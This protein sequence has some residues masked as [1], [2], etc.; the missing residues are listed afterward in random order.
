MPEQEFCGPP[1]KNSFRRVNQ[2]VFAPITSY[3]QNCGAPEKRLSNFSR[4][5][6]I[7]S[8]RAK[9]TLLRRPKSA[10]VSQARNSG[11]PLSMLKVKDT[12]RATVHLSYDGRVFK[13][14]HG[15]NA[16]TAI[17]QRDARAA[18]PRSARL[19]FRSAPAGGGRKESPH[20][21]HQL[22]R[23]RR[24]HWTTNAPRNCS[25]NWKNSA[26][27]TTT[28]TRATSPTGLSDGRFCLIDFEFATILPSNPPNRHPHETT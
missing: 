25:P 22:R 1:Q 24:T 2:G 11:R 14:Y 7:D 12:L 23:P 21:H 9:P 4:A 15:P 5:A 3:S 26:C 8:G 16:A 18:P 6:Q 19:Q 20:R 10:I 27:A 13:A 28:P 17:C